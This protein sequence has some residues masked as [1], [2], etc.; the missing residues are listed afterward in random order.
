MTCIFI[1]LFIF[2]YLLYGFDKFYTGQYLIILKILKN[3]LR[4]K[5]AFNKNNI[6]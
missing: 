3:K 1:L 2:Q 5:N 4:N 6:I